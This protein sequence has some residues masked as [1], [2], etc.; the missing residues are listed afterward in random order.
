MK[1]TQFGI[2]IKLAK[3]P[4][5]SCVYISKCFDAGLQRGG[6]SVRSDKNLKLLRLVRK[7][8]AMC[9]IVTGNVHCKNFSDDHSI[10]SM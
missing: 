7:S 8:C 3:V 6:S 10:C 1:R 5:A 9:C 2:V 4:N